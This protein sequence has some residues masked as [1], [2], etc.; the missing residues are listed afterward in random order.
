MLQNGHA[1]LRLLLLQVEHLPEL[2]QLLQLTEGLQHYQH[3]NQAQD[4]VD[5][6]PQFVELPELLV[7]R[8][9][10]HIIAEADGAE[11]DEAKV[12]RLQEV[13]VLLQG[14]E[15]GG[16]NEEEARNGQDR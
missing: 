15:D 1:V 10:G 5:C 13:P 3:H 12:E 7:G 8:L 2:L 6:D 4:Q 11:G 9:S 14:R 16:G